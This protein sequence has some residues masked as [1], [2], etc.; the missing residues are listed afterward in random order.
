MKKAILVEMDNKIGAGK[1]MLVQYVDRG[2]TLAPVGDVKLVPRLEAGVYGF[3]QTMEGLVI[4][5]QP[6]GTDKLLRFE[7]PVQRG[8]IEEMEKFWE[9]KASFDRLGLLHNR[10]ILLFGPPGSGKS[11]IVKMA[12]ED[13]VKAGDVVFIE[14]S[15]GRLVPGLKAFRSVEPNRRCLVVLEDAD[16]LGEH[17]LLQLFDGADTQSNIL[18][19]GTTNYLQRFS[20]RVLRPGRF[21]RKVEVPHPP[22]AG[23]KAY[24]E[25]KLKNEKLP[26]GEVDRLV[27]MTEGF[28]F[29]HLRELIAGAFCM[30]APVDEVIK[31]LKGNGIETVDGKQPRFQPERISLAPMLGESREL[32]EGV[33][34]PKYTNGKWKGGDD[35]TL[36]S[37]IDQRTGK[38]HT[39]AVRDARGVGP[40]VKVR[41]ATAAEAAK[42]DYTGAW[43]TAPD[44][45][46]KRLPTVGPF[47]AAESVLGKLDA[48]LAESHGQYAGPGWETVEREMAA[49]SK[50]ADAVWKKAN[51]VGEALARDIGGLLGEQAARLAPPPVA[52]LERAILALDECRKA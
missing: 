38:V 41:Q 36:Y 42:T 17:A 29:G 30:K 26:R 44:A 9:N 49:L 37:F 40:V 1:A 52:K 20:P 47:E 32:S 27:K 3:R 16:A 35:H 19:L 46:E 18:Y 23:R 10:G 51:G 43:K 12:T 14:S 15:I 34:L 4:E 31:R 25:D 8:I 50:E 48:M 28:S 6:I 5:Q 2:S 39:L 45:D 13:L 33:S 21:D 7:D 24:L 11:G 22:A